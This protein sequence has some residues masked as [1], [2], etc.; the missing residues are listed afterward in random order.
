MIA[1][2][3]T[4]RKEDLGAILAS[5]TLIPGRNVKTKQYMVHL[6]LKPFQP[7]RWA[8]DLIGPDTNEAWIIELQIADETPLQPDPCGNMDQEMYAGGPDN[9]TVHDG[10]LAI[11]VVEV[12]HIPNVHAW[13]SHQT[14]EEY[15]ESERQIRV[16]VDKQ[17]ALKSEFLGVKEY[18]CASHRFLNLIDALD[19]YSHLSR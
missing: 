15:A 13:E 17:E 8:L 19:K 1:Y 12:T 2:H 4:K 6:A 9:W 16:Y 18:W 5:K 3:V 14:P 10:P 7:G 11:K